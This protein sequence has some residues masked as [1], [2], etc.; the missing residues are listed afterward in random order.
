MSSFNELDVTCEECG[1][2]FKG[3]VWTAVH[4]KQDP[5]LKEVL[6]GGELNL[7]MCPECSH[8]AYQD[9]FVLYQDPAAELVAYVYPARQQGEAETLRPMMLNG[10]RQAQEVYEPKKRLNY[11][12]I[13]LFG[14]ESLVKMI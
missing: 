8:V 6:L 5:E 1:E 4:A 9:H 12:P 7:V 3:T 13:L 10:F 11:E 14:L 2:E